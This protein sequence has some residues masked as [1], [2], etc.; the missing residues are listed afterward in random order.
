MQFQ[1]SVVMKSWKNVFNQFPPPKKNHE[2]VRICQT[3]KKK[4]KK[5]QIG[6]I[7][8]IYLILNMQIRYTP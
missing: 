1:N 6:Q 5:S 4:Y 3:Q 7:F 2:F 8:Q